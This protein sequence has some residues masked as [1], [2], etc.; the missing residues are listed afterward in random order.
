M[1]KNFKMNI[2][3][4]EVLEQTPRILANLDRNILSETYGCFDRDYWHN[5]LVD[6]SCA[7]KQEAVLTLALLYKIKNTPYH[8]NPKIL[9]W[10]NA[11]L[12]FWTKIQ[13]KNGSFNEWYPKENSF[14][15]TAFSSYA[16]SE[17]LLQLGDKIE[18]KE[19]IICSLR[20]ACDWLLNKHEKKAQ[21]QE[22][23]SII[24]LYN[25]YLLTNNQKYKQ[26]TQKKIRFIASTQTKEGW[27]NEYGGADIGYLSL[28]LD[29]LAK[30]YQK[31]KDK[32]TL[33]VIDKI[34]SFLQYFI[35]PDFTSGGEYGS[36][37]TEYLIPHG[38]EVINA[39]TISYH[40]KKATENKS[41]I[42]PSLLDD[43]YLLYIGYIWL[44]SYLDS[45]KTPKYNPIYLKTFTKHFPLAKIYIYSNPKIYFIINYGKGGSFRLIFKKTKKSITDSGIDIIA[46]KK[47]TSSH[48]TN[49]NKVTLSRD[50]I[51]IKGPL[52][53]VPKERLTPFKNLLLRS[54]QLSLAK[55]EK[56]GLWV[57][58][59]LR[60]KLITKAKP[61]NATF[62]RE[63]S[64]QKDKIIIKDKINN[65]KNIRKVFLGNKSSYVYTPSSRYFKLLD[66]N[67]HSI[68]SKG[69]VFTRNYKI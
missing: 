4:K 23:G 40:I 43:R 55:S 58:N 27:F 46:N 16:I 56:I 69:T 51:I 30:Y 10:I 19:K 33:K 36:R 64:I 41:I 2:Y 66:I 63:I 1:R 6:F 54:F 7:R 37:S 12:L 28:T 15:A 65:V 24:S 59:S 26:V 20:K 42:C 32:T 35:H 9:E 13:E 48:L 34:L 18:N 39:Q 8:N 25:T 57:K 49:K 67:N 50:N 60:N 5:T 61:S 44:Q 17:T 38:F 22:L 31:T 3:L 14:V 68:S 45:N 47:L 52:W 11:S 53:Y 62:N 29:Y 21:N